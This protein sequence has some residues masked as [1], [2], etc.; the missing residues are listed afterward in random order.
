MRVLRSRMLAGRLSG[1]RSRGRQAAKGAPARRQGV[2]RNGDD[3]AALDRRR[4]S[5]RSQP[6]ARSSRLSWPVPP[7]ASLRQVKNRPCA[8]LRAVERPRSPRPPAS[9]SL[10]RSAP[11]RPC[12][13]AV[14][15]QP[16]ESSHP[17]L[18]DLKASSR[19]HP[20]RRLSSQAR[21]PP[22]DGYPS[23]ATASW[24][25]GMDGIS[26]SPP[27]HIC[28]SLN[29]AVVKGLPYLSERHSGSEL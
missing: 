11:S 9:V 27:P 24:G 10:Q 23:C 6:E 7:R 4:P 21:R 18:H 22:P 14:G 8:T 20:S 29:N 17:Y 15:A 19:S 12:F 3:R 13:N 16:P 5:R 1:A 28:A 25:D 26:W 2:K